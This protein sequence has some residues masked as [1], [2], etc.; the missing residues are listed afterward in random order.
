MRARAIE[1]QIFVLGC[2]RAGED[3][4]GKFGGHSA[5]VDPM[6]RVLVEGGLE[7]GLFTAALD[8][9]DVAETRRRLPFLKDRR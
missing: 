8:L 6:G 1:N 3:T 2:N 5:A 9:E 4:D 7:P